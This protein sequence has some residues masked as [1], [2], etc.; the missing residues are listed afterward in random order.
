MKDVAAVRP[1]QAD[2]H[3]KA[4]S[5]SG[6]VWSEQTYHL[7]AADAQSDIVHHLASPGNF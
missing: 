6:A 3:I 5:L 2:H 1:D 4:G 7:A